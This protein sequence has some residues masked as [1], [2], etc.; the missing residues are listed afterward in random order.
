MFA[1]GDFLFGLKLWKDRQ[2]RWLAR[3]LHDSGVSAT[4]ISVAGL[5]SGLASVFF[6][7]VIIS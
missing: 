2:L 1:F 4:V 6:C 7:I 5:V 3:P